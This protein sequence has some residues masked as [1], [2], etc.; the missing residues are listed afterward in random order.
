MPEYHV[1]SLCSKLI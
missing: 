1:V